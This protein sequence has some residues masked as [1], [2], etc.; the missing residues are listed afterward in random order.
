LEPGNDKNRTLIEHFPD[1]FA[2]HQMVTDSE[3]EPVNYIFLYVNPAFEE[4][5]GL[6]KDK[7]IGKKVTVV[8]PEL[9]NSSFD[10]IGTFG[11][12][13]L[14][15][16][17]THFESYSEPLQQWYEVTVFSDA[18][19]YFATIFHNITAIKECRRTEESLSK[20]EEK[21][22]TF[23]NQ[24]LVAI[25]L[26]DFAGNVFDVNNQAGFLLGYSY[27]VKRSRPAFTATA[28][29]RVRPASGRPSPL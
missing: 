17:N 3:G 20:S 28:A 10:W 15:G 25:I 27:E 5:A 23:I 29:F 24:N 9:I 13:A 14:T 18:P 2:Y 7:V 8:L 26:Y 12:V 11:K 4:M 1:A 6:S 19:D 16:N 22:R 21:F